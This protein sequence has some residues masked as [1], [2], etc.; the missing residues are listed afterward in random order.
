MSMLIPN[1]FHSKVVNKVHGNQFTV[2]VFPTVYKSNTKWKIRKMLKK[3][4][5]DCSVCGYEAEPQ[6][7]A[8]SHL[9]YWLGVLHQKFT[10]NVF[11]L[12][13]FAFGKK[14]S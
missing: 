9:L 13:I 2:D 3:N 14:E 10:P 8:F 1:R 7:L 4:G 11:K 12:A 6:Y 5:F